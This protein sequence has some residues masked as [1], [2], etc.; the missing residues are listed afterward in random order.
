MN[1]L[2]PEQDAMV[3]TWSGQRDEILKSISEK[4]VEKDK[5][6]EENIRLAN[7]N[8]ELH[9]K[10]QG[11]IKAVELMDEHESERSVL[12]SRDLAE[13]I[14]HKTGIESTITPML[15]EI[16]LLIEKKKDIVSDIELLTPLHEK[17]IMQIRALE[18][19][20]GHVVK[21]N[22]KNT[23]RVNIMISNL[24]KFLSTINIKS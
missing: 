4:E 3:K 19:T 9:N 5:L 14:K 2:T 6:T 15:K 21:V 12:V 1:P 24:K 18:H 22:E 11:N 13:L 17:F 20:V 16:E 7:S 10:I 8:S 23:D